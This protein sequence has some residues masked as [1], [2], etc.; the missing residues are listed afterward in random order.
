MRYLPFVEEVPFKGWDGVYLSNG[1]IKAVCVPEIGGRLMQFSLGPQDYLFM[2]PELL[3]A[4]FSY[5]EHAGDGAH[6]ELEELWRRQDLARAARL[7]WRRVNGPDRL[8]P[9]ST[10]GRVPI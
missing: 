5:E 6:R 9:Y 7:G 4:R 1:L 10:P 8:I 3:G 2:N